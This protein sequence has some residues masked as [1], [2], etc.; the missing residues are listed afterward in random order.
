MGIATLEKIGVN[1]VMAGCAPE[2]FPVVVAAVQAMSNPAFNLL[3]M[4]A[5]TNPVAPLVIVNGPIA[6]RLDINSADNVLGQGWKANAT[7]GRAVRFVLLNIGGGTPGKL[8][9]ACHGQPGKYSFCMAENEA[10]SPWP[11]FHVERGYAAEESTVT[12]IGVAGTQDVIHYARTDAE[13]ILRTLVHA[14]PRDGFKNLYSG[15]EP[16]IVFG[17]EQAAVLGAAGLS[18]EDVKRAFFERTKVP[19][20]LLTPETVALLKAR[21]AGLFER[22]DLAAVPIADTAAD[23]Q[24]VVAGG[25]GNHTVFMPTWGDTRCATVKIE[26]M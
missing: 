8:D 12:A 26:E 19:L 9:K 14:I 13:Q 3:P 7:I 22:A 11:P 20:A 23:V 17:P 16:L 1:A 21:R 15:G 25:S 24:I 18:K 6:R 2:Y 10:A 5:T 4:Q